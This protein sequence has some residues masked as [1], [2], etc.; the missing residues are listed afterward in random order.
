[1]KVVLMCLSLVENFCGCFFYRPG[2]CIII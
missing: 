1:M 2:N